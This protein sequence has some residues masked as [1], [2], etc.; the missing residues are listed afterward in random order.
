MPTGGMDTGDRGKLRF[1][2]NNTATGQ[3][4]AALRQPPTHDAHSGGHQFEGSG[5][6]RRQSHLLVPWTPPQLVQSSALWVSLSSLASSQVVCGRSGAILGRPVVSR[7]GATSYGDLY[8]R[9][10][11]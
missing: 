3:P 10:G 11:Q 7:M 1:H 5:P 2:Q 9:S 8:G 6:A 4:R